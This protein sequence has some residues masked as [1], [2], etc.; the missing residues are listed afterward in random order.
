MEYQNV[1]GKL[2][3]TETIVNRTRHDIADLREKRRI[4]TEQINFFQ[5]EK[6]KVQALIDQAKLVNIE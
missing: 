3:V 1:D 5:A 4:L 6:A 2:E